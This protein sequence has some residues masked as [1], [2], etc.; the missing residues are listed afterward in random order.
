M[1]R[2][3]HPFAD[4]STGPIN[5]SQVAQPTAN[6]RRFMAAAARPG[7][8]APRIQT[9]ATETAPRSGRPSSAPPRAA[10]ST[11]MFILNPG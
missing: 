9:R 10:G 7:P 11:P 2:I 5:T 4:G 6:G 3:N 1:V 8:G